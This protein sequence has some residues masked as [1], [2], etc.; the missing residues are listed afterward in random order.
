M[1]VIHRTLAPQIDT[2]REQVDSIIVFNTTSY[3]YYYYSHLIVICSIYVYI[4]TLFN[5]YYH[6]QRRQQGLNG[7]V[8]GTHPIR[9]ILG[10]AMKILQ[11]QEEIQ[12]SSD[13][14]QPSSEEGKQSQQQQQQPPHVVMRERVHQV[15]FNEQSRRPCALGH[16]CTID[17][18]PSSS[19]SSFPSS[20]LPCDC[21]V[22]GRGGWERH[23]ENIPYSLHE[24][25][26][27]SLSP[28]EPPTAPLTTHPTE[29]PT[30]SP[31]S[32]MHSINPTEQ[33]TAKN[34]HPNDPLAGP[35][36]LSEESPLQGTYGD[37][38][39]EFTFW[40]SLSLNPGSEDNNIS[41][42]ISFYVFINLHYQYSLVT[43][44]LDI[45]I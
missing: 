45:S 5:H 32:T 21:R 39:H 26:L 28:P 23:T 12:P 7:N 9:E 43:H 22:I 10:M 42:T 16:P 40:P 41:F 8:L 15:L 17:P 24:F 2:M 11:P 36:S 6:H 1:P 33:P 18:P 34:I 29:P 4:T 13:R 31:T 3:L 14:E 35:P 44:S 19:S 37:R 25:G 27:A 30:T 38:E 20:V